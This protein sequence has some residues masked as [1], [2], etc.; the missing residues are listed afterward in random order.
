MCSRCGADLRPLMLLAVRAWHLR[1][2]ARGL[3]EDGD[4]RHAHELAAEAQQLQFTP[5][6]DALR[7]LSGW[8]C[9]IR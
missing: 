1:R 9:H 6:G 5:A 2:T 3:L 8:L 4:F 7:V